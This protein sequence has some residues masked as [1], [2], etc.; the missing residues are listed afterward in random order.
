MKKTIVC[1]SLLC[2]LAG[3]NGCA[4][5]TTNIDM[6]NDQGKAVMELDYR[7]FEQA[8]EAMIKSLVS[9]GALRKDDNSRYVVAT[10][11]IIN[12]TMQRI[13]T[14]Q[15]MGKVEIALFKTGQVVMTSAVGGKGATDE[16]IY[17]VRD[18]KEGEDADEF[19]ASTMPGKG[20]IVLPE[21]SLSGKI[22]QRN[23]GYDKKTQ[24]VEY[25]FQLQLT[26]IASGLRFWQ[27]EEVLGK[28]GSKK[29]TP[30]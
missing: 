15:L 19:K 4:T 8:A 16:M 28:R 10:G 30:W 22:L 6:A 21:L 9:E 14:D 11:R 12:D 1:V 2:C 27:G 26:E 24:Q 20:Q 7:D 5:K 18:L 13:D 25:Y 3:L 29:S 17:Q 23:I